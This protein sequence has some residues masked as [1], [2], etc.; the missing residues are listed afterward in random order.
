MTNPV[1]E[2]M[3]KGGA[4]GLTTEKLSLLPSASPAVTI[5]TEVPLEASSGT[6][7][8]VKTHKEMLINGRNVIFMST[9]ASNALG[10]NSALQKVQETSGRR[11]VKSKT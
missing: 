7:A 8:A 1:A 4:G 2:L 10:L 6:L 5:T 11:Q 9:V 3:L